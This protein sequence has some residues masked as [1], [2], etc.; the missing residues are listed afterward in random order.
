MFIPPFNNVPQNELKINKN[1][2][3]YGKIKLQLLKNMIATK[4]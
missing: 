1:N 4:S 2:K 3:K